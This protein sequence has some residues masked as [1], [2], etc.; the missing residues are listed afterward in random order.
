MF[1]LLRSPHLTSWPHL[2]KRFP[3]GRFNWHVRDN[4][5]DIRTRL[6]KVT[7]HTARVVD[8][9]ELFLPNETVTHVPK[10]S[11][12]QH[13]P[14]LSEQ[15][16]LV[17]HTQHGHFPGHFSSG[18]R[19]VQPTSRASLATPCFSRRAGGKA[20]AST[21]RIPRFILQ[22]AADNDEPGFMYYFMSVISD[23]AANRL[24]NSSAIYYAPNMSFTPSYKGF[25]NK[26]MPLFAPRAFRADDFNDPYHLEGTSTLN[27]IEAGR[28]G[29][30]PG[31][32]PEPQLLE[33]PVP[34]QRVV[35]PLAAGPDAPAGLQDHLHAPSDNPGPVKWS[36]PYFD[37]ERSDKWVY[38][39]TSPIPDIYPRHTQWRHIEIPKY[40]AVA[41]M[42]L[43]FDRL[44][45]NQC[46][47]GDGNPRPNYFAGTS[48]CKNDTTEVRVLYYEDACTLAAL[49]CEDRLEMFLPAL[50]LLLSLSNE[51]TNVG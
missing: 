23:V 37:C 21:H 11:A 27:T 48:R 51:V 47:I 8:V 19:A 3:E 26:T 39:A 43:D 14:G 25:F 9:N 6:D 10:Y 42:E 28:S 40:V 12:A 33:R 32:H 45:I 34:H 20:V 2:L 17:A 31:R 16:Q 41:V 24:I 1:T 4:F 36:K 35:P 5:D 49:N 44:D 46:P 13:R 50:P 18:K 30:D 7:G 15:D 22:K 29:R 38:G